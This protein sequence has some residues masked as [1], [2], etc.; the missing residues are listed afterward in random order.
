M[1]GKDV[2]KFV[3]LCEIIE[4]VAYLHAYKPMVIHGDLKPASPL[5]FLDV[6][7]F[8]TMDLFIAT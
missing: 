1:Q 8:L 2:L 4:G 3:K 7:P 5:S 6:S